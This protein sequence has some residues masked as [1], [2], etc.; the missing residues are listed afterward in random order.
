[1]NNPEPT[2]P[3]KAPIR[4]V[5]RTTP[6]DFQVDELPAY[7]PSGQGE[8][9]YL[10]FRKRGLDTMTAVQMLARRL[11]VQ[12]RDSG[13][14][15]LKDRHAVTTQQ[16]SFPFPIARPV[17]TADE[18]SGDGITVLA[19]ERHGNKLK[20]GHLRGNRFTLVLRE[21]DPARRDELKSALEKLGVEGLPNRFGVQRFG[22]FGDN[23]EQA[24]AWLSGQARPPRDQRVKR[25]LFS[26]LQSELFNKVLDRRIADGTW[27]TPLPGEL[28]VSA[29]GGRAL[30]LVD[31]TDLDEALRSGQ[32]SP[33]G[34]IHGARMP[35]P[36]GEALAVEEAA[37]AGCE[38]DR[39]LLDDARNLGEGA[40][41]ALRLLPAEMQVEALEDATG[42]QIQFV[43]P[44]GAYAT[45]VL[46]A[47]CEV[48]DA[49]RQQGATLKVGPVIGESDE[50]PSGEEG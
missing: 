25:L 10:T 24:R 42:L 32:L 38:G 13:T 39:K 30:R 37:L 6:E 3:I 46:E 20:T 36:E 9:L 33:S 44:K 48:E 22:R 8:H 23:A 18:L 21:I 40:R 11:G 15:G 49:T 45:T 34:P 29:G 12:A 43:L 41:R 4:A 47:V 7:T 2:A 1:M 28:L 14:A 50:Q 35:R 17:P 26:A 31:V 19:V 5:I 27:G 16:A